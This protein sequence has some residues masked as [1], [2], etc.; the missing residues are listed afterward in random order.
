MKVST[1]RTTS[2]AS[3][4][5]DASGKRHGSAEHKNDKDNFFHNSS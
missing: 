1:A 4:R 5:K 2:G 3:R